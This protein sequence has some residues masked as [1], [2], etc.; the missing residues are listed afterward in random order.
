MSNRVF[1]TLAKIFFSAAALIF[2]VNLLFGK[3]NIFNYI[4]K[5]SLIETLTIELKEK[6]RIRE[7]LAKK[8]A[9]LG[10]SSEVNID[11]LESETIRKLNKIPAGYMIIV[12]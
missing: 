8:A 9:I 10:S 4:R 7:R 5:T 2:S 3:Y 11:M 12:E 6:N 1:A